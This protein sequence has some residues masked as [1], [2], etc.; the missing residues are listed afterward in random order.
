MAQNGVDG[1]DKGDLMDLQLDNA[2]DLEI[3]GDDLA[4]IDGDDAIVQDVAIRLQ[5]FRGEWRNDLAIGIPYYGE[6]LITN[7]NLLTVRSIFR[8][9]ILT[10]EGIASLNRFDFDFDGAP[11]KLSISFE[12]AKTEGGEPLV[13]DRELII[14]V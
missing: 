9:A 14:R 7:P 1:K 12:A 2:G 8:E 4:L 10:T 13:F 5:F 11:R 6:I 3:V